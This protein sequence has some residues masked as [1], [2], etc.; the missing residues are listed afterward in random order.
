MKRFAGALFAG[1]LT[2]IMVVPLWANGLG[3]D[4]LAGPRVTGPAPSQYDP[5]EF[6]QIM[7]KEQRLFTDPQFHQRPLR[8]YQRNYPRHF[9]VVDSWFDVFWDTP[10]FA[11]SRTDGA[12]LITFMFRDIAAFRP[13]GNRSMFS[14]TDFMNVGLR[15][16][17]GSRQ[18]YPVYGYWALQDFSA[19]NKDLVQKH[20]TNVA[21]FSFHQYFHAYRRNDHSRA[22]TFKRIIHF[23]D[24]YKLPVICLLP[25]T[26]ETVLIYKVVIRDDG[27]AAMFYYRPSDDAFY[28][29]ANE[30]YMK[31]VIFVRMQQ[32]QVI[33]FNNA[34]YD[35]RSYRFYGG[36][37]DVMIIDNMA[38]IYSEVAPM[39]RMSGVIADISG[40]GDPIRGGMALGT[41]IGT[42]F[43]PVSGDQKFGT[44]AN[45]LMGNTPYSM[46]PSQVN[47]IPPP[48]SQ[49]LQWPQ[50]YPLG[51]KPS[52]IPQGQTGVNHGQ[53]EQQ[54]SQVDTYTPGQYGQDILFPKGNYP[55]PGSP[56]YPGGQ[57]PPWV[58]QEKPGTFN[59]SAFFRFPW[60]NS[61]G[62]SYHDPRIGQNRDH[63]LPPERFYPDKP[64]QYIPVN[65]GQQGPFK[66]P[67]CLPTPPVMP[68]YIPKPPVIYPPRPTLPIPPRPPIVIRPPKPP[69]IIPPRPPRPPVPPKPPKPPT[70]PPHWPSHC[71]REYPHRSTK[72][73]LFSG[74]RAGTGPGKFKLIG[75]C[76][77]DEYYNRYGYDED[78]YDREGYDPWGEDRRGY[79]RKG[80]DPWGYDRRGEDPKGHKCHSSRLNKIRA[81]YHRAPLRFRQK[82]AIG[83]RSG[84]VV[85]RR[86]RRVIW[87]PR[88]GS[89][90]S[91]NTS[92]GSNVTTSNGSRPHGNIDQSRPTKT[93]EKGH[94]IQYTPPGGKS[95][96]AKAPTVTQTKTTVTKTTKTTVTTKSGQ[97]V[98]VPIA[99]R[100][101]RSYH[102]K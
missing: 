31:N 94:V 102:R 13:T 71:N 49:T 88:H 54:Y 83:K 40:K 100:K 87:E 24:Y 50:E 10:S 56:N 95:T 75:E 32:G 23:L 89:T 46:T 5:A 86:D 43:S 44:I 42:L 72:G 19:R 47:N 93:N 67:V 1:L 55:V 97:K 4:D 48:T 53:W 39:L 59:L 73:H 101:Y 51:V 36:L 79:D 90:S 78:G 11:T 91:N 98:N 29:R 22:F 12:A 18:A 38:Q 77:D 85:R 33:F 60:S 62:G 8:Q 64:G 61:Q 34:R 3:W 17:Q 30:Q 20:M 65:P 69:V 84:K 28:R 52:Y 14:I 76:Y 45:V 70:K 27:Q 21:S 81:L 96:G 6:H 58:M 74:K 26:N 92:K 37:D 15:R 68:P 16:W 25:N 9:R 35:N 80:Y 63:A 7:R 57:L 41:M 82:Y 2:L 66:P 99:G